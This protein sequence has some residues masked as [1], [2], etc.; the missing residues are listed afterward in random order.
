M[1]I[2][3]LSDSH[4]LATGL[5]HG[6]VDTSV[7][8]S[9]ALASARTLPQCDL[10]VHSGDISEDG[11]PASY[12]RVF[13][14]VEQ[15]A[16]EWDAAVVYALGNHDQRGGFRQALGQRG[17][18]PYVTVSSVGD[19]RIIALD[20]SVPG[21]G[22]GELDPDQLAWLRT[23]LTEPGEAIIVMHHPPVPA[24]T[25][26][27]D[28]LKLQDASGFRQT[29]AGSQVGVV[30]AG[31]YHL[32]HTV[33]ADNQLVVVAPAIAN[34][35]DPLVTPGWERAV[36]GTGFAVID[37]GVETVVTYYQVPQPGDGDEVFLFPPEVA[38]KIAAKAGPAG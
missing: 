35:T 11:T 21:S 26:L 14:A 28:A 31:H 24:P 22:Y 38:A 20:T 29:L 36:R 3:H 12:E 16:D 32:P 7:A 4:I 2:L 13:T 34:R 19:T 30:L 5:H 37:H 6:V 9:A 23:E 15:L 17:E 8:L 27:H 1:R 33:Q 25:R 18:E 10:I